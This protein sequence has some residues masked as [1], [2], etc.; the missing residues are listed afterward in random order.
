MQTDIF[1]VEK[2]DI[3]ELVGELM[4][5]RK[6]RYV[7]VEDAEG[8]LEGLVTS[9]LITRRLL[10]LINQNE[11]SAT[12]E[13]IMIENPITI[14]PE[15][16][17]MDALKLMRKHTISVLPVVKKKILVGMITESDFLDITSRLLE[18]LHTK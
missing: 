8:N 9:R 2:N 16:K 18:R 7:P 12:V 17:I 10:K 5:W 4:D 13:D 1:T 3:I 14:N 6:I 15:A 11:K